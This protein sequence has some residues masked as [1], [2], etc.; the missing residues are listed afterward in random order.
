MQHL[1]ISG[2]KHL[3]CI[4]AE[5]SKIP[6]THGGR[7]ESTPKSYLLTSTHIQDGACAHTSNPTPQNTGAGEK[8]ENMQ[9]SRPTEQDCVLVNPHVVPVFERWFMAHLS[10][11]DPGMA[12]FVAGSR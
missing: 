11:P 1:G 7:R 3:L 4:T 5:L 2:E 8:R 12:L 6:G 9:C 10:A